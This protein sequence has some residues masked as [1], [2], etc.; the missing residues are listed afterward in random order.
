MNITTLVLYFENLLFI[1]RVTP[2]AAFSTRVRDTSCTLM[3][4]NLRDWFVVW[5][6]RYYFMKIIYYILNK[7]SVSKGSIVVKVLGNRV[8][9]HSMLYGQ[10]FYPNK[11]NLILF[12]RYGRSLFSNLNLQLFIYLISVLTVGDRADVF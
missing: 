4:P 12:I 5:K 6:I 9:A 2:R 7:C 10:G 11:P 3:L 8:L 1:I